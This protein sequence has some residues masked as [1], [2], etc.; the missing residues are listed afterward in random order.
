MITL[1]LMTDRCAPTVDRLYFA[2]DVEFR[3]ARQRARVNNWQF[4]VLCTRYHWGNTQFTP[5]AGWRVYRL[6]HAGGYR[7]TRWAWV[8]HTQQLRFEPRWEPR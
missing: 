1:T 8:P 6:L 3:L 2:G 7:E 5:N 4:F